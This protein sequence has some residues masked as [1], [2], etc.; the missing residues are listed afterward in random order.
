MNAI[1]YHVWLCA[2]LHGI[3]VKDKAKAEAA[4]AS[5]DLVLAKAHEKF[6]SQAISAL[7]FVESWDVAAYSHI[8]RKEAKHQ[9]NF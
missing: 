6:A 7:A 4:R 8:L 2:R 1:D 9:F 3:I 5:G